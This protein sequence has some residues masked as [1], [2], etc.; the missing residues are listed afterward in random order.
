[1]ARLYVGIVLVFLTIARSAAA[2]PGDDAIEPRVGLAVGTGVALA[3]APMIAGGVMFA[4]SDD[5]GQRQAAL[6][7]ALSGLTL[8]PV[9]GHLIVREWKRAGLFALAPLVGSALTLAMVY[10]YPELLDHGTAPVR[11]TFGLGLSLA[12]MGAAVGLADL[13][14]ASDRWRRRH[15]VAVAPVMMAGAGGGDGGGL[16]VGGRF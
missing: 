8:A 2:A 11:V 7:V 4:G 15:P 5:V 13:P 14:G 16:A 10:P 6:W 12:V 3:V 9:A 1:M